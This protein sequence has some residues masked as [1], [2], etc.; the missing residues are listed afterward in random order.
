MKRNLLILLF[1]PL[2]IACTS[3]AGANAEERKLEYAEYIDDPTEITFEKLEH[4]FGKAVDGDMVR[5]TYKFTNTGD[6]NLVL[7]NVTGSCGCTVPEDWPKH[8][9]APGEKGEIEVVFNSKSRVGNVRKNVRVE[10][11]TNPSLTVLTL[12]GKVLD[13]N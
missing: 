12:T 11:N 10:A 5:Y 13:D 6:K 9:I 3:N 7:I 1:A 8:P 2:V 4:D